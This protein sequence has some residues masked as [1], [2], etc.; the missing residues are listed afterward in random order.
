MPRRLRRLV[1]EQHSVRSCL[2][3]HL[4]VYIVSLRPLGRVAVVRILNQAREVGLLAGSSVVEGE[5]C[6]RETG[7]T[8]VEE[9]LKIDVSTAIWSNRHGRGPTPKVSVL[10]AAWWESPAPWCCDSKRRC[11]R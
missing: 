1:Q 3:H 6:E 7:D 4:R 11:W 9:R 10:E 2:L 5:E 8:D